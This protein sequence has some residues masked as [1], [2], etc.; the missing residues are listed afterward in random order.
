MTTTMALHLVAS[1][2]LLF[3]FLSFIEAFTWSV[4]SRATILQN[5]QNLARRRRR[6]DSSSFPTTTL[7][8]STP[9]EHPD[10]RRP[11]AF[12]ELLF[13]NSLKRHKEPF[14]PMR[15][16]G[17]VKMYTCGPTVY[18][19]AHVGN[20]RAF[21]T[22]DVLKRALQYFGYDVTHVCNL[23]DVDDKIIAKCL[24]QQVDLPTL[25]RKYEGAFLEDL[26]K[27]NILPATLYPRATQHIPEMV[28][29]IQ[30][31]EKKELAYQTEDGSWYFDTQKDDE[32][33][34]RLVELQLD[35]ME[36]QPQ[37]EDET[38]KR[39]W[40]DFC[41]WKATKPQEEAVASWKTE[42]GT[43]RPGWHLE[44][45]A[46]ARK[47][48]G[49]SIDVHCG[50]ID[51]KFP[52]HE[53]EIAQ[54]QGSTGKPFCN[55]W[56]HNGFVNIEGDKMSK[57]LGNFLTLKTACPTAMDVRAY[58]Y[59]VVTSHYRTALSFT[60]AN[61]QS[62][63]KS[64]QRIDKVKHKIQTALQE[65]HASDDLD[66]STAASSDI[67]E[68]VVPT[69]I[70]NFEAALKDDLSMPRAAASLFA[71]VKAAEGEFKRVDKSEDAV[72]LDVVGLQAIHAAMDRMDQIFGI[73]FTVP[74]FEQ[75]EENNNNSSVAQV[76]DDVMELV[77]QR[78]AA[79]DAKDWELADSLRARIT[80]L[81]FAVKD[82]KGGEPIISP[83]EQ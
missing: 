11:T 21:L 14:I 64:L 46:M 34:T 7:H 65:N 42:I 30:T 58:R 50:G 47:Y 13:F 73:F 5:S 15:D 71:L 43:G 18:D 19:S 49:D 79:K 6:H 4:S 17:T 9:N 1:S 75:E 54:S 40:Q 39:H 67:A 45:S 28:E 29:M 66:D 32:Y 68:M 69:Q 77:G 20:F 16:D 2:C 55:C 31:L 35:D 61:M 3:F 25:T 74:G 12:G 26:A 60:Q 38:E 27:L 78:T 41:L 36:Q 51:L 72:V 63:K 53:N 80:E 24:S 76:P 62:A 8:S 23:T 10:A 57:S 59:L 81:G 83:I 37:Q 22:Y 56:I 48:L 33:G 52:H 70:Q 82:V 44:C